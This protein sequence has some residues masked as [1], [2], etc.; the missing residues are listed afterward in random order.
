MFAIYLYIFH[1]SSYTFQNVN[2][3]YLTLFSYY[4]SINRSI[5]LSDQ[6]LSI[7]LSAH[8]SLPLS[9]STLYVY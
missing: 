8:I 9:I 2:S 1:L 6:M 7:F 3:L 4:Y 5:Y